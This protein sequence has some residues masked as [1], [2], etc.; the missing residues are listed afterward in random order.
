ELLLLVCGN[1][2]FSW[3]VSLR[4][5]EFH[6]APLPEGRCFLLVAAPC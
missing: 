6:V 1:V 3:Q 2:N 4:R 5:A